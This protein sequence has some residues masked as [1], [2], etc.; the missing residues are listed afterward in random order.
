ML[1]G[2]FLGQG[3]KENLE[4]FRIGRRHDQV[5]TGPFLWA[6]RSVKVGVF[7]NK[8]GGD[9]WP[10][11]GGGPARPRA[12]HPTKTC[13][14]GEHDP[15]T[16]ATF[17]RDPPGFPYSFGKALFLNSICASMSRSG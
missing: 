12:V 11:A 10:H 17:C 13:F 3:V 2:I 1:S 15:Q 8:L 16:T 6:N 14:I 5:D 9:P 7:A 4:A